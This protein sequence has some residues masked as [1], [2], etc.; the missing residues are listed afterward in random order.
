M[1]KGNIFPQLRHWTLAITVAAAFGLLVQ[2]TNAWTEPSQTPP[3]G[4]VGAPINTSNVGQYK[5]GNLILNTSGI[6]EYG[7]IVNGKVGIGTVEPVQKLD[8]SGT[9]RM[10][11]FEM[12]TGASSGYVLT[13]DASGAGT[14]QAGGSTTLSVLQAVYPVGSIYTS[15]NSTNPNTLFG[16]GTWVAF[17]TGRALVGFD[18]GD[19]DFNSAEKTSGEKSH[20]LSIAEMPSHTHI[21]NAHTHSLLVAWGAT[22]AQNRRYETGTGYLA[23]ANPYTGN[24]NDATATNQYTGGNGAHNNVQPSI[25][26]YFFKRTN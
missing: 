8:V 15:V 26:V 1:K 25:A 22:V 16:F 9:A 23:G 13:S 10:T 20:T 3:N 6:W 18:S 12:P 7:L 4:D 24:A 21:Q 17:G 14:W 19:S 2:T 5:L 11:G